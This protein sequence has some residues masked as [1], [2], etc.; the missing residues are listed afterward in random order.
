MKI[1]ADALQL[2]NKKKLQSAKIYDGKREDIDFK[3]KEMRGWDF[4]SLDL[5]EIFFY[6]CII[7]GS[8]FR[9]ANLRDCKF[10]QCTIENCNFSRAELAGA[11]F[12]Q[13]RLENNDFRNTSGK[14]KSTMSYCS[15]NVGY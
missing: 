3:L 6:N 15:N 2:I 13:C 4:T 7:D 1:P 14:I 9:K 10:I 8:I 12:I 11:E 5:S